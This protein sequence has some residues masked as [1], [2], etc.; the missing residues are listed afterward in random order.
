MKKIF[1]SSLLSGIVPS[2]WKHAPII[3]LQKEGNTR[4]VNNLR[5]ISLLPLPGKI[6]EK[7]VHKHLSLYLE[8]NNILDINQ[9]GFRQNHST[10]NSVVGLTED[11]YRAMNKK[12]FTVVVYV[13]FR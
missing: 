6:L 2:S 3:P 13:D 7:I 8:K 4:D 9:G 11:I 1:D 10:T 5:P 12:E